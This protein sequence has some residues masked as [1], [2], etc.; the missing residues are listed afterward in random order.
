MYFYFYNFLIV[1]YI[2]RHVRT[3]RQQQ[4]DLE[5][6]KRDQINY[7]VASIHK[8]QITIIALIPMYSKE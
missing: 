5:R 8:N 3:Q 7:N 2:I 1:N 6:S 4:A